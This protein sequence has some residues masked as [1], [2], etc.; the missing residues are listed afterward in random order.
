MST[1]LYDAKDMADQIFDLAGVDPEANENNDYLHTMAI[2]QIGHLITE[3]DARGMTMNE[4][5]IR[6]GRKKD[7]LVSELI[8]LRN[9]GVIKGQKGD[10]LAK[11]RI[12][13]HMSQIERVN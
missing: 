5:R 9:A 13:M 11:P 6:M 8:R 4:Q 10:R 12:T 7:E 2:Q 1:E 3:M